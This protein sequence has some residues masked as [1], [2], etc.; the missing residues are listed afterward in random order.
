M[1]DLTT[2]WAQRNGYR[3]LNGHK[4]YIANAFNADVVLP[5]S[6]HHG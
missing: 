1:F 4:A 3:F 5:N 2:T 6:A